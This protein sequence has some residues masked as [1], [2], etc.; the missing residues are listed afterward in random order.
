MKT[1]LYEC[2]YINKSVSINKIMFNYLFY[3]YNKIY[4]NKTCNWS[5]V[6]AC[7]CVGV[8]ALM[9][10]G[11]RRCLFAVLPCC[12]YSLSGYVTWMSYI[13]TNVT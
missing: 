6:R 7:G 9:C 3:I 4:N 12:C 11:V 8:R 2:I 5:C 13:M 1:C 10:L